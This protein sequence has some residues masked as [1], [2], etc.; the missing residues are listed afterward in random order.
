MNLKLTI[1]ASA[2][3]LAMILASLPDGVAVDSAPGVNNPDQHGVWTPP[4][5][6]PMPALNTAPAADADDSGPANS[7]APALDK[8]GLPW[9][10]RIHA[11]TKNTNADGS[12]KKKRGATPELIAQVEA[13]LRAGQGAQPMPAVPPAPQPVPQPVPMPQMGGGMPIGTAPAMPTA[14]PTQFTPPPMPQPVA[15]QP[16]PQPM[17]MPAPVQAAPAP[18]PA[19]QPAPTGPIDLGTFMQHLSGQMTKVDAQGAPLVHADYLAQV[20]NEISTAYAPHGVAPLTSITDIGNNPQMIEY[21]I[22]L[23]TRDGRW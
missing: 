19:P 9:D 13:E 2:S 11:G 7:N 23:M 21:A 8:D 16:A 6:V 4:A 22:A 15:E 20:T 14:M 10:E 5:P 18:A 3:T 1:E 12:W 17:P